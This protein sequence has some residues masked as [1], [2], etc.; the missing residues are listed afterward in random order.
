MTP[1]VCPSW[2][3]E[4]RRPRFHVFPQ[5]SFLFYSRYCRHALWKAAG[6]KGREVSLL[7]PLLASHG[8]SLKRGPPNLGWLEFRTLTRVLNDV[9]AFRR[10]QSQHTQAGSFLNLPSPQLEGRWP[11]ALCYLSLCLLR[12]RLSPHSTSAGSK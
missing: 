4:A 7:L 11:E 10:D 12:P 2:S 1:A 3:L 5:H 9:G 8:S 6:V